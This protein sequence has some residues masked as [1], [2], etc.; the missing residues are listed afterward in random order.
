MPRNGYWIECIPINR[1]ANE[2][3]G[4]DLYS[5]SI[6]SFPEISAYAQSPDQAI[7]KLRDKLKKIKSHYEI[8]GKAMP[9]VD[10]PVRPPHRLRFVQGW[11]SVFVEIED[12][13]RAELRSKQ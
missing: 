13:E 9:S 7:Q 12:L 2:N 5:A 1:N 3:L 11:M 10:N 4:P 6:G 8:S